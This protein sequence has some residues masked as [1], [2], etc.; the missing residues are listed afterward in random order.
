MA[1]W[2]ICYWNSCHH[3]RKRG[4][5]NW[6]TTEADTAFGSN[7]WKSLNSFFADQFAHFLGRKIRCAAKAN[8]SALFIGNPPRCGRQIPCNFHWNRKQAIEI[9]V[10]KIARLQFEAA[11]LYR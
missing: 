4:A 9:A 11:N 7:G 10:E 6:N 2:L 3:G 1:T 8:D 5:P